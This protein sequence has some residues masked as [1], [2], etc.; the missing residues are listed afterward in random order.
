[1]NGFSILSSYGEDESSKNQVP[2]YFDWIRAKPVPKI[3]KAPIPSEIG[4]FSHIKL[5]KY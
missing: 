5:F 1:L 2:V 4:A 3:K